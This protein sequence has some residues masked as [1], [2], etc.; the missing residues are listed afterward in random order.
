MIQGHMIQPSKSYKFLGVIIDQDLSFKEHASYA[1]AKGITY[2][3]A[4]NRMIKTTT[5]IHGRLMRR[6]Y[7]GVVI[8]K[9]LYAADV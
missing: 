7:E 1:M 9:M 3:M 5:G 4:C 6:L 8:P 2:T